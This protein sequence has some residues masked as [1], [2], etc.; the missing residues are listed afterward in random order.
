MAIVGLEAVIA[1]AINRAVSRY[2]CYR[3]AQV[4][5]GHPQ[6][7]YYSWLLAV[8]FVLFACPGKLLQ[9]IGLMSAVVLLTFLT[10]VQVVPFMEFA[11][12]S[13]RAGRGFA[14]ASFD[15]LHPLN[16]V[17]LFIPNVVGVLR[18]G[19]AWAQG[20]SVYGYIGV[21]AV[22][23]VFA[24][25]LRFWKIIAG[26][27]FVLALGKYTRFLRLPTGLFGY[28]RIPVAAA[29]SFAIHDC[30]FRACSVWVG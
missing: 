18:D 1:K 15:S 5:A 3:I 22:I 10:G 4:L 16:I 25:R 19:T 11:M 13:T 27:A 23:F 8:L 17:R 2:C 26:V 9:K 28:S 30:R 21:L 24:A 6:L 12:L 14:Y 7:T 29:F 20:G